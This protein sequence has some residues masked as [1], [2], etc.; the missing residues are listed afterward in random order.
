MLRRTIGIACRAG[1]GSVWRA[2]DAAR[3]S[4]AATAPRAHIFTASMARFAD[5]RQP[6]SPGGEAEGA[7]SDP[8]P[9]DAIDSWPAGSATSPLEADGT[10]GLSFGDMDSGGFGAMDSGVD[11]LLDSPQP[12]R[13][14]RVAA[15]PTLPLPGNPGKDYDCEFDELR[16]TCNFHTEWEDLLK[17]SDYIY[18]EMKIKSLRSTPLDAPTL[19]KDPK[20]SKQIMQA[21]LAEMEKQGFIEK[22]EN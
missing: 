1:R 17:P 6:T 15:E 21:W 14:R 10:G 18:K 22:V 9:A 16:D 7:V 12:L 20:K 11:P 13:Q 19:S 2:A 5:A 4:A 8:W 3:A